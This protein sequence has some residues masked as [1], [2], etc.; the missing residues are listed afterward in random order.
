[1]L[2]IIWL[3]KNFLL[4]IWCHHL[5]GCYILLNFV[6]SSGL[7]DNTDVIILLGDSIF[8]YLVFSSGWD[9]NMIL[10]SS[11]MITFSFNWGYRR[12]GMIKLIFSNILHYFLLSGWGDNIVVI[13]LLDDNC[14]LSLWRV[15]RGSKRMFLELIHGLFIT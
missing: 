5:Y 8:L 7:Y 12:A 15:A 4:K 14:S 11:W 2:V 6:L 13:I 3:S 1:M 9:D 10:S